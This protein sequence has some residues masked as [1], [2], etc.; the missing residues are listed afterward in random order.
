[1][2]KDIEDYFVQPTPDIAEAPNKVTAKPGMITA[3]T[4]NEVCYMMQQQ[5]ANEEQPKEEDFEEVRNKLSQQAETLQAADGEKP[6]KEEGGEEGRIEI[7]ISSAEPEPTK[8][9]DG[10]G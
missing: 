1:M 5:D 6:N 2:Y 9:I 10:P 3:R 4:T 7:D 8:K